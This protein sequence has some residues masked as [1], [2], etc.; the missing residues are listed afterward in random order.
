MKKIIK[1]TESDLHRIVRRVINEQKPEQKPIT[2][3]YIIEKSNSDKETDS[4]CKSKS[5]YDICLMEKS[6]DRNILVKKYGPKK[7][8]LQ[9]NGY[10][11]V[12]E[13]GLS[14]DPE[15]NIIISS[16]WKK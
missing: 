9:S 11:M 15:G 5:D 10:S 12:E 2:I 16:I 1:L 13:S 3:E 7:E 4:F 6:L 8:F 14:Q